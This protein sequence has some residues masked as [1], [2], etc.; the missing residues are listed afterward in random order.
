M[1][2]DHTFKGHLN[3]IIVILNVC[4]CKTCH[5][6]NIIKE[7]GKIS[8]IAFLLSYLWWYEGQS[9]VN[10]CLIAGEV[11]GLEYGRLHQLCVARA[12]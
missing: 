4:I 3:L 10:V 12:N 1:Q 7:K 6:H 5:F 8:T 2:Q 9:T 11:A